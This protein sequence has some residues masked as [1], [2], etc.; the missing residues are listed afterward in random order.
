MGKITANDAVKALKEMKL[1]TTA[2]A[3]ALRL[4]TDARAVATALRLP[5]K[6]GRVTISYRKGIGHYR[7]KRLTPNCGISGS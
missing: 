1:S 2:K 6:D 4:G 7:F 5:V 3:V